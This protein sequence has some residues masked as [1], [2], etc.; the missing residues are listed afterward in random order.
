MAG[1]IYHEW[2][3]TVLTIT[4][5]SGTS[6]A[7]LQGAKGDMGVRGAQ[8]VAGVSMGGA[9]VDLSN[10]YTKEEVDE[11]IFKARQETNTY[12]EFEVKDALENYYTKEEVD[13]LIVSGEEVRY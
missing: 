3:G 9:S 5:D 10:Y 12:T 4:S 7:D 1:K 11:E 13:K 8:G 6:S 2:N